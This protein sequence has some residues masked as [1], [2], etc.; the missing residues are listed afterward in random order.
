MPAFRCG[1][2]P[3]RILGGEHAWPV[4]EGFAHRCGKACLRC[5]TD[6]APAP[7]TCRAVMFG[8]DLFRV[9][10]CT[11]LLSPV[12]EREVR[13]VR[14]ATFYWSLPLHKTCVSRAGSLALLHVD[15][16][17]SSAHLIC[18]RSTMSSNLVFC[19]YFCNGRRTQDN[20]QAFNGA[21]LL[22]TPR[23]RR[24]AQNSHQDVALFDFCCC[25]VR[26]TVLSSHSQA[27]VHVA[28]DAATQR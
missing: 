10:C 17:K 2:P 7:R 14:T 20:S 1:S 15:H 12:S 4:C 18:K 8:G 3:A 11:H 5:T 22:R 28:D 23:L 16:D 13:L 9:V 25:T 6:S 26:L 21:T 27:V 19:N 24:T